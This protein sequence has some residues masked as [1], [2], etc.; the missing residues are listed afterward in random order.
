MEGKGERFLE[1]RREFRSP[2]FLYV[3]DLVVWGELE[4]VLRA[5]VGFFI[6]A[7]KRR[8]LKVNAG[9]NKVM[10]L[11]GVERLD[12]VDRMQLEHVLEFKYLGSVLDE[13]GTEEA[14]CRRKVVS[15]RR[16]AGAIR[17]S[18]NARDLQLECARVV[19]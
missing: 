5:I 19:Q 17:S 9:K 10:V 11:N 13:S 7:C 16:V 6:D 4:K 3:D 2:G 18:V 1:E 12:R 8:G 14:G 15:G